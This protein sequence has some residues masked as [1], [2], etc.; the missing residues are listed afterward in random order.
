MAATA[1]RI[2]S[3]LQA[4]FMASNK[5]EEVYEPPADNSASRVFRTDHSERTL[6]P[7]L[8]T[9]SPASCF[10]GSMSRVS[11]PNIVTH[12]A[13]ETTRVLISNDFEQVPPQAKFHLKL[14]ERGYFPRNYA[15]K[16]SAYYNQP[17]EH[18]L[19]SYGKRIL[20]VVKQNNVEEFRRILEAGLSPNA[21][22]DH[23]ESLLH[24]VCRHG[25]LALFTVLIAYDVDIQQTDD[26]GRTPSI[27]HTHTRYQ[28]HDC[29]WASKPSFEIARC[30]L[31]RDSS[32]LFL[33]DARGSLPLSYVTKSLWGEWNH[34]MEQAIDQIFPRNKPNKDATPAFCTMKPNS[35]PVPDPKNKIPASLASMVATGMMAP[36]EVLLAM[37]AYEDETI[38]CSEYDSSEGSSS[39]FTDSE[40]DSDDEL[41]SDVEEELYRIT[42]HVGMLKLGKIEEN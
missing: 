8:F 35:R 26:Y 39:Y 40:I 34:F 30:L 14:K 31:E 16:R 32:L 38:Q 19:A 17:T 24:M 25:K 20:E 22:N 28:M 33:F 7:V 18:Q 6:K 36:Y 12:P 1:S 3:S 21:C 2:P 15:S 37:A 23:G 29:C 4:I 5:G 42:G 11:S 10:P 13:R 9:I 27:S 41:D